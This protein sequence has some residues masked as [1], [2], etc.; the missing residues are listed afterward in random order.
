LLSLSRNI[1]LVV[2]ASAMGAVFAIG[3]GTSDLGQASPLA[4]ASGMRLTFVLAGFLMM[5]A[6]WMSLGRTSRNER[7]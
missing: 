4:I 2:G 3:V 1:G 6:L 7:T 5:V